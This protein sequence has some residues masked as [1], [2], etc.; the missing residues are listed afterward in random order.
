MS[1]IHP[2]AVVSEQA[3]VDPSA[4]IGP[5]CIIEPGAVIG[6]ECE[7][8]SNVC[9][10]GNTVMG[11]GN[12]ICHGAAIGAAPQDLSYTP[13][14]ARPLVIGEQNHFKE[15]VVISCGVKSEQ[16]T[17]IGSHNFF[18]NSSHVGHDCIVGDHNIFAPSAILGGHVE[19][20]HHVFLSGLVAVHQFCRIGAYV[21][22]GG[23]SG[24]RQD[25]PPYCMVNGQYARYVGLNLVGLKRNGFSVEQRN[26]VKR[27]YRLLFLSGLRQSEALSRIREFTDSPEAETILRFIEQAERGLVS[28]EPRK[29]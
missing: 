13:D 25:V 20:D 15:N 19:I 11:R 24:V 21:M 1:N 6:P 7:L 28:A 22:V 26:V 3:E 27:V 5:F 23:V 17:R 4:R 16:G 29:S 8:V 10:F 14:K 12:T 18:M 2:S 9:V